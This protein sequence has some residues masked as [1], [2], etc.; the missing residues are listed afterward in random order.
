MTVEMQST[1]K[2]AIARYWDEQLGSIAP[3][4][5]R[6]WEDA[7]T[8]RHINR[9]L[10]DEPLDGPHAAFHERIAR[11]FETPARRAISVGCGIGSKEWDL[12]QRGVVE[13]FDLFEISEASIAH[14]RKCAEQLGIADRVAYHSDDVFSATLSDDYDLVYWNNSLHHMLDVDRAIAWSKDRLREGGLL[15]IDDFVGPTRF[16]WTDENLRWANLL[17]ASLSERHLRH[18]TTPDALVAR[19]LHR[20]SADYVAS[21]DPS[22]AADSERILD[23]IVRT[24]PNAEIIRTGGA[25]YHL[26]LNDIFCNF[27]TAEDLELLQSILLLDQALAESGTTHYAVAFAR[28]D[29]AGLPS[30]PPVPVPVPIP[31]AEA[32]KPSEGIAI[33]DVSLLTYVAWRAINFLRPR[34]R[35]MPM[36]SR[37]E[38]QVYWLLKRSGAF[39]SRWYLRRYPDVREAKVDP[40]CHYIRHGVYEGRASGPPEDAHDPTNSEPLLLD[41]CDESVRSLTKVQSEADHSAEAGEG[42]A[43]S[44]VEAAAGRTPVQSLAQS[45]AHG[46]AHAPSA[47][48]G[49]K[50]FLAAFDDDLVASGFKRFE[51]F[52]L[53][54]EN[55]YLELNAEL[56]AARGL[57]LRRH[58]FTYG[59]SEGRKIFNE[60]AIARHLGSHG[61]R[62]TEA[63]IE[64]AP[65]HVGNETISV[66]YN[67]SGNSFLRD[68]ANCLVADLRAVG[69]TVTL[70]TEKS[71]PKKLSAKN[72]IVGPHEFFFIG[73]GK[74]WTDSDVL[75][76]SVVLNTEQAQTLWF[77]R[78]VP[79]TLMS[80]GVIDISPQLADIYAASGLPS[81]FSSICGADF[82][83]VVPETQH[84]ALRT[85]P[86]G[87]KTIGRRDSEFEDRSI[88]VSF[89]G[90]ISDHRDRFFARTARFFSEYKCIIYC[91]RN[92]HPLRSDE[93][94]DMI[95][96][97]RHVGFHSKISLNIHRDEFGYFEWHRI[98]RLAI[99]TG[100]VV[101]SEPCLPHPYFKPNV[102]YF[103]ESGRHIQNL[104]EWLLES[105]D[106]RIAAQTV[107]RNALELV[108][109]LRASR[110]SGT[111]IARFVNDSI[112]SAAR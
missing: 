57:N 86:N 88:D 87:A 42:A 19:E 39:D 81:I 7:T 89:F 3:T 108:D 102:H 48:F 20:P 11:F 103:E 101:V 21:L 109:R 55:D 99:E 41:R 68:I 65:T 92:D 25:L 5:T 104:V 28:K 74:D 93:H 37:S 90:G 51:R 91:R 64:P 17:R 66:F 47:P 8:A 24:F 29:A 111:R 53:F 96:V 95:D 69:Q 46:P 9:I 97:A 85:L 32:Q 84:A 4:R 35:H 14:G 54:D 45:L 75:R 105:P 106:G 71:D 82:E 6:W 67:E 34:H 77:D 50:G 16:Q 22:E 56:R 100:S 60:R 58:A 26:A 79:F 30:A 72:I 18:P 112:G 36:L 98:V 38:A 78:S 44:R 31:V 40:L 43:A 80:R 110:I 23:A 2:S 33:G 10:L 107:R 94:F 63:A 52:P 62:A 15:A 83:D 61:R 49:N 27:S 12:I 1:T 76:R 70:A 13:H 59:F 73:K